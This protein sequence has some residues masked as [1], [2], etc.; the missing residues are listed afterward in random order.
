MNERETARQRRPD[1]MDRWSQNERL[2]RRLVDMGLHV[3]P[4]YALEDRGGIE[5]MQVAVMPPRAGN[6]PVP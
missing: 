5:W 4:Y 2:Y 1:H 6:G 3:V